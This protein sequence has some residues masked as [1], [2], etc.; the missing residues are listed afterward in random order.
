ME[1]QIGTGDLIALAAII[2]GFGS[3]IV[4]FR[5]QRE[6][7]MEEAGECLWLPWADWLILLAIFLCVAFV[8]LL[9]ATVT[10]SRVAI[11]SAAGAAAIVLEAG[12]IP[13]IL[14]HYRIFFGKRRARD[15][16]LRERGEPAEKI[17]VILTL[18]VATLVFVFVVWRQ[19]IS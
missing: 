5:I 15:K 7:A 10:P 3:T 19:H 1:D 8:I 11:A 14:A 6:V 18:V 2:I 9:L 16:I 4:T 17:S 12:Y 13:S